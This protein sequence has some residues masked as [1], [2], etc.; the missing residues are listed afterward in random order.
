MEKL[1]SISRICCAHS[2]CVYMKFAA[3]V[4][5]ISENVYIIEF[6]VHVMNRALGPPKKSLCKIILIG[7]Q[8]MCKLVGLCLV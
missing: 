7:Q 4:H 3:D 8:L 1:P 6:S 2:P 5:N